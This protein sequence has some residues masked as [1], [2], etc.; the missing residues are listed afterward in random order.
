LTDTI[1]LNRF[2]KGYFVPSRRH[3]YSRFDCIEPLALLHLEA[4]TNNRARSVAIV[5]PSLP[6]FTASYRSKDWISDRAIVYTLTGS[7]EP[8]LSLQEAAAKGDLP[9]VQSLVQRGAKLDGIEDPYYKT[10][11]HRSAIAGRHTIAKFLLDKGA[12]IDAR[13]SSGCTP[14]HHAVERGHMEARGQVLG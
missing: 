9:L 8:P 3:V 2:H 14:L 6:L 10:A 7:N 11:L 12:S 4:A 5:W 13:D 1:V